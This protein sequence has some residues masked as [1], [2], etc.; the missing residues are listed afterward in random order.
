MDSDNFWY[1]D[2]GTTSFL[3]LP[4][5][6]FLNCWHANIL[7]IWPGYVDFQYPDQVSETFLC[8]KSIAV[9]LN[10]I[11]DTMNASGLPVLGVIDPI[12]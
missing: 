12:S 10:I 4:S 6:N 9:V 2:F 11:S 7:A 3:H 8:Y 1:K 5:P